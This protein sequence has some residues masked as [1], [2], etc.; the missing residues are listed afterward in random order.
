MEHEP[1]GFMVYSVNIAAYT[2]HMETKDVLI[3]KAT[4]EIEREGL[5]NFSLRAVGAAA[6]LSPMAVYRHFENKQD[7]LRA[8]GEEAFQAFN[9]RVA[10][11]P[12]DSLDRWIREIARTYVEFYLDTPGQ[13]DACFVLKTSFERIYPRDFREGKSPVI[14]LMEKR[15]DAAQ[16]AGE[17]GRTDALELALQLWAQVHG[18]VMLHKAGRFSLTRKAFLE[19]CERAAMRFFEGTATRS[20]STAPQSK[21]RA[22][23]TR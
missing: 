16:A 17:I 4:K 10:A 3:A 7:L 11:I 5:D 21:T 22:R 23:R 20:S 18:L 8:V 1:L 13:F 9:E 12:D 15:L 14:T 6:G 2:V 19:L